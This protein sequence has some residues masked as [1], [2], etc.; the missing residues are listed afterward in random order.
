MVLP[1]RD[2]R[3]VRGEVLDA[4]K[5]SPYGT[6]PEDHE[7]DISTGSR[8]HPEGLFAQLATTKGHLMAAMAR[9]TVLERQF[10]RPSE[11]GAAVVYLASDAAAFVTAHILHV[12]GETL[13]A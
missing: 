10:A 4:G 2:R 8:W 11:I 5:C 12:D 7:R 6:L 1:R 3:P 9:K 13:V